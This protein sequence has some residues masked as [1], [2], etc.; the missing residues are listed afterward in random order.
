MR[1]I[2][3]SHLSLLTVPWSSIR[4]GTK[5]FT[6]SHS[7][8]GQYKMFKNFHSKNML[9]YTQLNKICTSCIS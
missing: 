1:L 9:N 6:E 3:I 4:V 2:Y 8:V 5:K 7:K